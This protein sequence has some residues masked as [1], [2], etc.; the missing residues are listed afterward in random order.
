MNA[1]SGPLDEANDI[2]ME[3]FMGD[4]T[5]IDPMDVG[6]LF[7]SLEMLL[8]D[9]EQSPE[10]SLAAKCAAIGHFLLIEPDSYGKEESDELF[11]ALAR[12]LRRYKP[13]IFGS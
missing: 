11:S 13:D 5:K 3:V 4:G 12:G 10:V 7:G 8:D 2:L 9:V 1:F 6:M